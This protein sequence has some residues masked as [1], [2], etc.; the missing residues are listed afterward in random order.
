LPVELRQERNELHLEILDNVE[1]TRLQIDFVTAEID[2]EQVI[3][4]EGMR[5]F[6]EERDERVNRANFWAFRT[7]GALWPIADGSYYSQLQIT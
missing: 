2:E 3:L 5:I 1:E 6:M 7:N 4:E